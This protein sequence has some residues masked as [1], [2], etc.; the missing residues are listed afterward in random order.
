ME[1]NTQLSAS[2]INT[3]KTCKL[4]YYASYVLGLKGPSHPSAKIGSAIHKILEELIKTKTLPD[5]RQICT[6]FEVDEAE[7]PLIKSIIKKTL[8]NGYL[9]DAK[10]NIGVEHRFKHHLTDS[11]VIS[12]SI[13]RLDIKN[14][15]AIIIDLKS[16]KHP[17]T[18]KELKNNYQSKIYNIAVTKEYPD[19]ADINVIFWFVKSQERQ[20]VT[21][22]KS[23]TEQDILELIEINNDICKIDGPPEPTKNKYCAYCVY[24]DK[25]PLFNK[26]STGL[27][28]SF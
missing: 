23:Q 2:K 22:T 9:N 15:S 8:N 19:I 26:M 18:K 10:Y 17:Y 28:P 6:T 13:D 20:L 14:N 21:I 24:V 16:G 3:F 7:L 1:K 5:F 25:C 11:L 4:Q 12:G 27:K